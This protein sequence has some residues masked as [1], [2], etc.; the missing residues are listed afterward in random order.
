MSDL[1]AS[2]VD[3]IL[4]VTVGLIAPPQ[5]KWEWVNEV[6]KGIEKALNEFGGKVIGGDCSCGKQKILAITAIGT[7]GHLRL[8]RSYALD[9][10]C[11]VASGPH[12][13]SSLGLALL[14]EDP[15]AKNHEITTLLRSKAIETHQRPIPP[16]KALEALINCKPTNIPWRAAGT[17]SSDGLLEA[18]QNLCNSS[19]CQAVINQKNLPRHEHWPAGSHW[20]SWCLNGG[21]DYELILSLPPAWAK[22][23]ITTFPSS[24]IIGTIKKGS[25]KIFWNNGEEVDKNHLL[26]FK[27]F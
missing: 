1:A 25:P 4:G 14:L 17:D 27:H 15:L 12:G 23:L 13:L 21:E 11:L 2:G 26:N 3:Q 8:H 19:N 9:G 5:T 10:D 20:D 24:Q 7:V 22:S 6:Y 18:L 16:L